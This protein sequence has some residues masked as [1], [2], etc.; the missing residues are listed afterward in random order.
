M[1]RVYVYT[2]HGDFLRQTEQLTRR[3]AKAFAK[4]L[5][6]YNVGDRVFIARKV[7]P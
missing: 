3:Q 7:R 2:S 4:A 1:W 5:N 6:S